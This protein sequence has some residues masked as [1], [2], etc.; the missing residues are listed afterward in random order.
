MQ[1]KTS[2]FLICLAYDCSSSLIS[3]TSLSDF[4]WNCWTSFCWSSLQVISSFCSSRICWCL[5]CA[6]QNKRFYVMCLSSMYLA[7]NWKVSSHFMLK[8]QEHRQRA[9]VRAPCSCW[10]KSGSPLRS[11]QNY[12]PERNHPERTQLSLKQGNKETILLVHLSLC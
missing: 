12:S 8:H 3:F 2:S 7:G 5:L 11:R 4:S 10:L 6:C 9:N 1:V